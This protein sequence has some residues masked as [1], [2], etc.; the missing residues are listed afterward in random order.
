MTGISPNWPQALPEQTFELLFNPAVALFASPFPSLLVS[1]TV[2]QV[3]GKPPLGLHFPVT[4]FPVSFLSSL[5]S[6]SPFSSEN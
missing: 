3:F 6:S 1:S 5:I 4:N 2:P